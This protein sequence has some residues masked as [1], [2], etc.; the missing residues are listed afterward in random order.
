MR[1]GFSATTDEAYKESGNLIA[2]TVTNIRTVFS[3][4]NKDVMLAALE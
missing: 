1:T 2:E 3:F 4:G